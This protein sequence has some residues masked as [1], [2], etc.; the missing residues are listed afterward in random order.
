MPASSPGDTVEALQSVGNHLATRHQVS[1]GPVGEVRLAETRD[2]VPFDTLGVTLFG[3]LHGR[4]E[5]GFAFRSTA[6]FAAA[7]LPTQI[8][9]VPLHPTVQTLVSSPIHH[10]LHQLV[11]NP[12]GGMIGPPQLA[13]S[14]HCRAPLLGLG[15]QVD[16]RKPKGQWQLVGFEDRAGDDRGLPMAPIA[17][18]QL[19]GV[20]MATLVV[21]AVRAHEAFGP[22]QP[23]QG[24]VTWVFISV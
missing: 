13:V 23:E 9:I 10:P 2:H 4:Y 16:G 1:T 21:A 24:L 15:P 17:R 6:P 5:W 22:A 19:A 20:Q 12:P 14:R 18:A 8:R 7:S 3:G 11:L